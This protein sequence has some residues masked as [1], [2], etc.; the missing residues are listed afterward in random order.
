[1]SQ[2]TNATIESDEV[3]APSVVRRQDAAIGES[4][5]GAEGV[6]GPIEPA[7]LGLVEALLLGP[8]ARRSAAADL[9][10]D[11][12]RRRAGIESHDVELV[13]ADTDL[14]GE[15]DPSLATQLVSGH[16]LGGVAG[17]AAG[18]TAIRP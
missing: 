1:V 5:I 10:H 2:A 11:D 8:E 12:H 15:D 17:T 7:D 14:P 3:D 9:D 6:H 18:R 4:S 16:G 13:A